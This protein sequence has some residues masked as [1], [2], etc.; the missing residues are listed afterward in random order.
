M[1]KLDFSLLE[2]TLLLGNKPHMDVL[3]TIYI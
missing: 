1:L 3:E 2:Q